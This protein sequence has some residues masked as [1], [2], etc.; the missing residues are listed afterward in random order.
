MKVV[1][2]VC[3]FWLCTGLPR[4]NL[5]RPPGLMFSLWV[6]STS[7]TTRPASMTLAVYWPACCHTADK[8]A[9]I[10]VLL[11][12]WLR[13]SVPSQLTKLPGYY[14]FHVLWVQAA[15]SQGSLLAAGKHVTGQIPQQKIG[16][17]IFLSLDIFVQVY[18]KKNNPN[19]WDK[20]LL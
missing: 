13:P 10:K 1:R 15:R 7:H 12:R 17:A 9:L 5:P 6:N 19:K 11:I 2:E 18:F 14:M 16:I 20:G 4:P 8:M 3:Y